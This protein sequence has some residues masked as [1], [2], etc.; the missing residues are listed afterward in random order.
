M[1]R[2]IFGPIA[3]SF[4]LIFAGC[5]DFPTGSGNDTKNTAETPADVEQ[6]IGVPTVAEIRALLQELKDSLKDLHAIQAAGSSSSNSYKISSIP[7]HSWNEGKLYGW[8]RAEDPSDGSTKWTR[9]VEVEG[10]ENIES[11]IILGPEAG[12]VMRIDVVKESN[13]RPKG[14]YVTEGMSPRSADD[15]PVNVD[16]I[17]TFTPDD[18]GNPRSFRVTFHYDYTPGNTE[19]SNVGVVGVL[20]SGVQVDMQMHQ[21]VAP[22]SFTFEFKGDVSLSSGKSV[23]FKSISK[24]SWNSEPDYSSVSYTLNHGNFELKIPGDFKI[25]VTTEATMSSRPAEV[26]HDI[27]M[28]GKFAGKN[29]DQL[30]QIIIDEIS[31]GSSMAPPAKIKFEGKDPEDFDLNILSSVGAAA[32]VL[33]LNHN[34]VYH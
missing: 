27:R 6:Q 2:S 7:P 34:S 31:P 9:V 25:V 11:T 32:Q 19:P 28:S 17:T 10:S 12:K 33:G 5:V 4:S 23:G 26:P 13:T 20:P 15:G 14:V 16:L 8:S 24:S 21:W 3:L 1:K 30:A 22:D 29:G 18:G